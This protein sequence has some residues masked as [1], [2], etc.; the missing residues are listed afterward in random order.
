MESASKPEQAI[1]SINVVEF[2]TQEVSAGSASV[3][4][5]IR[6]CRVDGS[7]TDEEKIFLLKQADKRWIV[8]SANQP[9]SVKPIR[10]F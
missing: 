10:C 9:K 7:G 4:A 5:K 2:L 1:K 3:A 6:Y 8:Y